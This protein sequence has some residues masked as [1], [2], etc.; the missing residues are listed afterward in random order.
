MKKKNLQS[1]TLPANPNALTSLIR[2]GHQLIEV[3][4]SFGDLFGALVAVEHAL[5]FFTEIVGIFFGVI[6]TSS[7]QS[8]SE[9]EEGV[10][11]E[12]TN[13]TLVTF[14]SG[15]FLMGLFSMSKLWSFGTTGQ[16]LSGKEV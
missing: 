5:S 1:F 3:T 2:D 14:A 11:E 7:F 10:T 6:L 12:G 15:N 4:E 9:E 13:W 8:S 16:N